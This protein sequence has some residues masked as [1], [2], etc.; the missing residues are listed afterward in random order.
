[1]QNNPNG[2]VKTVG[3]YTS[4]SRS[5]SPSL[6]RLGEDAKRQQQQRH[7]SANY[8]PSANKDIISALDY[9][10]Q[11]RKLYSAV[12]GRLFIVV[13]PYQP[14]GEGEIHLHKGDRVKVLNIGEG[15]FWEGSTRGHVGWFPAE[16]VE[17]VQYKPNESKPGEIMQ[18][19]SKLC[20]Q[21]FMG[22]YMSAELEITLKKRNYIFFKL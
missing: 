11:K 2:T 9:Q 16:C 22:K 1:M 15:G 7:I 14:Q 13:K 5:R 17:E 21:F 10:G 3:S 20:L 12:P 8:N 6:N 19:K 4:S 18:F